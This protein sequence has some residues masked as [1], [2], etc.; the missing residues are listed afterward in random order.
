M[1]DE[2]SLF[3]NEVERMR[4]LIVHPE[5]PITQKSQ[6][7]RRRSSQAMVEEICSLTR[8]IDL[9]IIG[10]ETFNVTKV[11]AGYLLGKGQC[12]IIAEI[13]ENDEPD[14]VV[15]NHV[16][17]PVQQRNL[18][19]AFKAKVIDRTGLILEIFGARAQTKE[20]RLQVDLAA[21][22]YQK[23]RLVRSWTHLERQRGGAGFMGGPG[24]R[25]I[26]LDRRIISDKITKLKKELE[27]VKRT[28]EL[29]RKARA[30][31]PFPVV[32]LV[33]YTNAG[34]STL[35]NKLTNSEVFAQDLLFATLDPTLRK[36]ELPNGLQVILSDTVGFI[37]ELP[38]HLIAAFRATLEE[39]LHADVILHV[40]DVAGDDFEAQYQDVIDILE[41]LDIKYESDE[42]VLE[43]YNK[44]DAI[45]DADTLNDLK[46]KSK[47]DERIIPISAI[48]G[49]GVD[50]LLARLEKLVAASYHEIECDIP[51]ADGRALAWLYDH[52]DVLK[53]EDTEKGIYIAVRLS[54]VDL[55]RF[56]G[57]YHYARSV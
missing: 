45:E 32:A 52:G 10:V 43:V 18:E 34:K 5:L 14:I 2:S 31:V 21:L 36:L 20:G 55:S 6:S 33:G 28:R 30:R 11:Q 27:T 8:A 50:E 51:Y 39:T 13:C 12:D 57:Q 54:G 35:F 25:Q 23:S 46:R 16:L 29:G 26:E 42:R 48:S 3:S 53:R 9:D 1:P 4:A 37:S 24:E 17:S 38:T 56:N 22:E 49:A 40:C 7:E 44:I 15:V 19:K 41:D 47:Y